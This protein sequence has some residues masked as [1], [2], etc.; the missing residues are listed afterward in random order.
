R[1]SDGRPGHDSQSVGLVEA[2]AEIIGLDTF[3]IRTPLA[4]ST[5][6]WAALAKRDF[7]GELPDPDL[8][9]GAGHATHLPMLLS[10]R[11]RGG[12]TTVLMRPSLPARLFG[13]CLV[14][15][16]DGPSETGNILI[17]T[18]PLNP[19]RPGTKATGDTG[20]ILLGGPSRHFHWQ[21][22][23]I[24]DQLEN[25]LGQ[26]EFAW[27]ITDSP[28]TPVST[29]ARL[30][31][32]QAKGMQYLP[33][34]DAGSSSARA[35]LSQAACIWV[36]QDSMSMV[37]EALSTGAAVGVMQLDGRNNSRLTG[38]APGLADRKLLTLYDEWARG[39]ALTAP[40]APLQESRRCAELLLQK[41]G[42]IGGNTH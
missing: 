3:S 38:V 28:R 36:S 30:A 35:L 9:V 18:G 12:V 23:R 32:L 20:L 40:A 33:F 17:T 27:K 11:I 34:D 31:Q 24:F 41:L 22:E 5:C 29:R 39:A 16:H 6:L 8:L 15:E 4:L 14:P 25:I 1:F 7:A 42:W 13:Y 37:Y 26:G 2:L 19:I 10:Q 21:E